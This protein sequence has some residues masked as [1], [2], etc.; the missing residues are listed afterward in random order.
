VVSCRG[1]CVSCKQFSR[2]RRHAC[3]YRWTSDEPIRNDRSGET[4]RHNERIVPK[5]RKQFSQ[6]FRLFRV[7]GYA[8]HFSLK[9]D[10][11]DWRSSLLS[12]QLRLAQIIFDLLFDLTLR[13]DRFQRRLRPWVFL[14]PDAMTP[15]HILNRPLIGYSLRKR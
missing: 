9:F 7:S 15:A 1:S 5:R 12:Q 14:R 13:D 4:L 8:I 3:R 2:R 11:S 10:R 6:H